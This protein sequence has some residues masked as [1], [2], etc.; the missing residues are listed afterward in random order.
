MRLARLEADEVAADRAIGSADR[1]ADRTERR[2]PAERRRNVRQ[3]P[4]ARRRDRRSRPRRRRSGF[5]KATRCSFS[6]SRQRRLSS[7][8]N[9]GFARRIS[10]SRRDQRQQRPVELPLLRLVLLGV[11]VLLASPRA[12]AR[13][14]SAR[15]RSRC[16]TTATASPRARAA[17]RTPGGR[18]AGGTRGG[19]PAC[20]RRSSA[21]VRRSTRAIW[22]MNS[23]SSAFVFFHVKYVYDCEKPTFA[24]A[25]SSPAA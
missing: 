24:S 2:R 3:R 18:R 6:A 12:P 13:S 25:S 22:P 9:A 1:R 11:E 20:S 23:V 14:R 10:F 8:C 16:R 21:E 15:S 4:R 19:C 17:P 7:C 5:M